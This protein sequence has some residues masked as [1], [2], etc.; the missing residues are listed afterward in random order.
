MIVLRSIRKDKWKK[1]PQKWNKHSKPTQNSHQCLKYFTPIIPFFQNTG[2]KLKIF[3]PLH[4]SS[5]VSFPTFLNF[6][7]FCSQYNT[8]SL[9]IS[10]FVHKSHFMSLFLITKKQSDTLS[11][12]FIFIIYNDNSRF[13]FFINFC[14]ML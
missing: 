11:N 4:G 13:S 1:N 6:S 2:H 3:S 10:F 5:F 14:F 8:F 12:C 7:I 9:I